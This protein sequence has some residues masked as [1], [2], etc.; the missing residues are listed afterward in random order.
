MQDI[1]HKSFVTQS[2]VDRRIYYK[3]VFYTYR[4]QESRILTLSNLEAGVPRGT[5]ETGHRHPTNE[6]S[7]LSSTTNRGKTLRYI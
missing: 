6:T 2:G 1:R 7:I 3:A 5:L 4:L